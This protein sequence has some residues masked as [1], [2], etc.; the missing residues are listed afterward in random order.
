MPSLDVPE[1][2]IGLLVLGGLAWAA[3]QWLRPAANRRKYDFE[4]W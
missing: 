3:Y 2:L 1:I 4:H